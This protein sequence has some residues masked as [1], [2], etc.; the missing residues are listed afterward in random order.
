MVKLKLI[1]GGPTVNCIFQG[2]FVYYTVFVAMRSPFFISLWLVSTTDTQDF[3]DVGYLPSC[4][5]CCCRC[6]G[7]HQA[8][9]EVGELLSWAAKEFRQGCQKST[10]AT[11]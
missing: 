6:R 9:D 7:C 1:N 5:S 3:F 2:G 11:S 8:K 10:T 4:Q